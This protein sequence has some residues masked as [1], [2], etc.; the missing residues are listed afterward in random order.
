MHV[1]AIIAA[2]GAGRRLGAEVPKQL[3][4]IGGRTI[5]ARSVDAFRTHPRITE[6]IVAL[7]Q[8]LAAAPPRWLK[9]VRV[10]TGGDTRQASVANAFDVVDAGSQIVLVH[11]AARPFVSGDVISRAID[12]AL[13]H[14]AAIASIPVHDTVKRVAGGGHGEAPRIVETLARQAIYLAQTPQA[15]K[16]EVLEKAVAV[17]RAGL[18]A[19]DEAAL[20]E[21]AGYAVHIVAGDAANVKI[22]TGA[23]LDAA[24]IS[25]AGGPPQASARRT[26]IGYDLHKLVEGRPLI[27]GGVTVPAERGAQGHSDADVVCHA[28]TDAILGA[29]RAGD[30]GHHYPDTDPRWKGAASTELLRN[31]VE[32]V[33]T[34]GFAVENVDVVIV[35]ERPKLGPYKAEMERRLADAIGIAMEAVSVKAKT[36]EG[37]DAI[38]RGEAVAAHAVTLLSR[39]SS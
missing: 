2:G 7:P 20:A 38:G 37:V 24:R 9:E 25:L 27:L 23:D 28:V 4:E 30:I 19:T 6:V 29:A 5:L 35:L 12:G 16:R 10:V 14:G 1:T 13:A 8:A 36:N 26:G 32:I 21:R 39:R 31:A 3:L 33:R 34:A 15:F 22:T 11:D 18:E 17:G